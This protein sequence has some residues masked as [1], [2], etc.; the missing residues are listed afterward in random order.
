M[1]IGHFGVGF[2]LKR[3][4]P[5]ISLGLLI[6]ATVW[7]DILW[8]VFLLL[9]WEH[10]RVSIGDTRWTPLD[11]YDY[12]CSHSL[13]F[14]ALWAT[15]LALAYRACRSDITG[16]VAIWIGVVSHWVLDW[17][18]HRPDMPLYPNGPKHGLGLW[19]SIPGTL[20]VE[21]VLFVGG[22]LLYSRGTRPRDPIGR[23]GFWS[24]VAVLLVLYIG[25]RFSSPPQ[26]IKSMAVSGLIATLVLIAW[27]W[28][29]DRHR[30]SLSVRLSSQPRV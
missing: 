10:A 5:R 17:L 21:L 24:Y 11:L 25:D 2:G 13:I 27:P 7:A 15:A 29:F 3:M 23:Y 6:A 12:P 18:T 4:A 20:V 9:G 1:F 28:W 30:E 14:M 26:G 8:T 19:N 16:A 22:V